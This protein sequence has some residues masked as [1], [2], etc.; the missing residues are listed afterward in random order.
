MALY[1]NQKQMET[2]NKHILNYSPSHSPDF[3]AILVSLRE[4]CQR[5]H[6]LREEGLG[7]R[8]EG[9]RLD[10]KSCGGEP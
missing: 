5:E 2:L 8:V 10:M 4:E 1:N 3:R 7:N 9:G 6:D